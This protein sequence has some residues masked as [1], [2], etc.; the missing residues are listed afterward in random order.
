MVWN[1][2]FEHLNQLPSRIGSRSSSLLDV[3]AREFYPS[4]GGKSPPQHPPPQQHHLQLP[5]TAEAATPPINAIDSKGDDDKADAEVDRATEATSMQA[6]AAPGLPDDASRSTPSY[7]Q[8][9]TSTSSVLSATA[10]EFVPSFLQKT[11]VSGAGPAESV[12]SSR[13]SFF[14]GEGVD[15]KQCARCSKIFYVTSEGQY[16]SKEGCTYHWGKLRAKKRW[17]AD[18]DRFTCCGA[19]ASESSRGCCTCRVHVW[20]LLTEPGM[21]GPLE[22]FVRTKGRKC[23]PPDG[24]YGIYSLDGEMCFT[25]SGLELIKLTVVGVEGRLVYESLVIPEGEILD[26][27]TRFSG[28]SARDLKRGPSKTLREVQNDVMGFVNAHTILIGHGLENDLR[29]LKLVHT[30]VIDTSIVFP[31]YFGLPYRRSL[32]SL[33]KS[34]LK[35]DIQVGYLFNFQPIISI[36]CR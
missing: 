33:V 22:G 30:T 24:N 12:D 9:S 5:T 2:P 23:Y 4:C 28:I 29:A 31:H 3:N 17:P 19:P 27:N 6:G 7:L 13:A 36:R 35:R 1:V 10:K 26:Y 25:T 18:D 20:R 8:H 14:V 11:E 15:A 16:L 21:H 32:K 34:Y